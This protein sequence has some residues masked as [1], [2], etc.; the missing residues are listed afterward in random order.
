[1][2]EYI[3]RAE[4]EQFKRQVEQ[5]TEEIKTVRVEVGSEDVSKRLDSAQEERNILKIEMQGARAD[6]LQIKESQADLRD[7]LVEHSEDLKVIKDKQDAHTETLGNLLNFAE[8]HD[9]ILTALQ[10][11]VTSIKATQEQILALLQQKPSS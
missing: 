6:I 7:K 1:M 8:S 5:K 11:D 3:T 4:F 2:E 9:G 10:T